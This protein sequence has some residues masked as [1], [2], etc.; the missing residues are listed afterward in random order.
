MALAAAVAAD[1]VVAMPVARTA[2]AIESVIFFTG[3][4]PLPDPDPLRYGPD[5]CC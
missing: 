3:R 1:A 5:S 2:A 4:V